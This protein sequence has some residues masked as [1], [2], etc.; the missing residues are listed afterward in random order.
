MASTTLKHARG[1]A[2]SRKVGDLTL[3]SPGPLGEI[4]WHVYV[5]GAPRQ[6]VRRKVWL[7]R[8]VDMLALDTGW[9]DAATGAI[10]FWGLPLGIG[11]VAMARDHTGQ[12]Q[13]VA[14]GAVLPKLSAFYA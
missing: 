10:T 2:T 12:F 5:D 1:I 6:P 9:S 7:F 11:Y 14:G 4:T 13:P 8:A 3:Y